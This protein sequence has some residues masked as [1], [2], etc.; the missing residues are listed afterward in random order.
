[1]RKEKD[2]K[3]LQEFVEER[4]F[5][6]CEGHSGKRF[7]DPIIQRHFFGQCM[8]LLRRTNDETGNKIIKSRQNNITAPSDGI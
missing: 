7:R 8:M 1:M 6:E 5:G 4:F 3:Q 2:Q